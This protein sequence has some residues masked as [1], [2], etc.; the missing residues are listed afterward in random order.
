M[1]IPL[2]EALEQYLK[3]SHNPVLPHYDTIFN[4][5]DYYLSTLTFRYGVF[6]GDPII[7]CGFLIH[8]CRFHSDH[9]SF[10]RSVTELIHPLLVKQV[11]I[12]TDQEFVI[13]DIF[14]VGMQLY[15]WNHFECD[16]LWYLKQHGNCTPEDISYISLS[17]KEMMKMGNEVEFD[18][19]WNEVKKQ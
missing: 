15:C 9:K 6:K 3:I 14:T 12:I 2:M 10:L 17:F 7:P 1:P 8:S 13:G 18:R 4:A 19:E 5:G 11:N 16:L